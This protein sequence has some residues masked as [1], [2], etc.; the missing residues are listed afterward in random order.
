MVV[1]H[2]AKR[3]TLTDR[4]TQFV[5]AVEIASEKASPIERLIWDN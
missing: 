4:R 3:K 2:R 1:E 5:Q